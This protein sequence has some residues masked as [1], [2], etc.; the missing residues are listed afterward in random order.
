[1]LGDSNYRKLSFSN[2]R[3]VTYSVGTA[4]STFVCKIISAFI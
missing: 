1:M 2:N 3:D 4:V